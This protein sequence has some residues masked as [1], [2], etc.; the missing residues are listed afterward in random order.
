MRPF[1]YR[2]AAAGC[3]NVACPCSRLVSMTRAAMIQQT[4]IGAEKWAGPVGC[5][6]MNARP[7]IIAGVKP[8]EPELPSPLRL[9]RQEWRVFILDDLSHESRF[10]F[11]L[12]QGAREHNIELA[13]EQVYSL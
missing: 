1:V 3:S 7:D 2:P 10:G 9:R 13:V 6:R 12:M 8:T 4:P 5:A 11:A